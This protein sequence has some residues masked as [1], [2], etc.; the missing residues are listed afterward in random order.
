[1][2]EMRRPIADAAASEYDYS[3]KARQQ[4]ASYAARTIR[5]FLNGSGGDWDWDGFTSCSL[6]DPTLEG[7]RRR[8]LGVDLPVDAEGEATLRALQA[9]AEEVLRYGG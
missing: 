3:M 8:A 4:E 7:I 5:E 9:E 2:G 1:M 6:R